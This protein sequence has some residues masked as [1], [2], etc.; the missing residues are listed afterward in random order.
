MKADSTKELRVGALIAIGFVV[1]FLAFFQ[2]GGKE[3]L[4]VT[5]I[6][7]RARFI[8]VQGLTVGAPVRVGGMK[9]GA[10]KYIDFSDDGDRGM[11]V[12][13]LA[14]DEN[15]FSRIKKDSEAKLG[16]VGLLGDRTVDITIGSQSAEPLNRGDYVQTVEAVQ[17]D[18][19]L[20]E[21]GEAVKEIKTTAQNAREIAWKINYG[22]GSLAKI[23]ND[24]RLYTNLDSLL[25]IWSR[26]SAKIDQ[27]EGN[28]A[29]IIN[30]PDLYRNM[31]RFLSGFTEF[32]TELNAGQGT[33]GKLATDDRL[34]N[35]TDSLLVS[36]TAALEKINAGE[37]TLG[38][39]IT[40]V[41]LYE[42][43]YSTL[44]AL[45]ILIKDIKEHP[46][47]YVKVSL[48]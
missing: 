40:N 11:I 3:G 29:A 42:K 5:K 22:E 36:L 27:G 46:K 24:P 45:D 37:G 48:F 12:V 16:T 14:I 4:F 17:L 47:K 26:I 10:V 28:L 25:L 43:L 21:S 39:M 31:N 18:N 44:D 8:D 33:L 20:T 38:Q 7:L 23:I 32:L 15:S 2:I 30:D 1:I 34:F 35:H 19:L 6:D 13:T 9:V 41:E